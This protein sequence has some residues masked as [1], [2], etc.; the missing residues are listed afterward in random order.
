MKRII[1]LTESDLTRI[2]RRVLSEGRTEQDIYT[3]FKDRTMLE[4]EAFVYGKD[5][6]VRGSNKGGT[7]FFTYNCTTGA[8]KKEDDISKIYTQADMN[9]MKEYCNFAR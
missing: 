8:L 1:R 7:L 5:K 2:V 9:D 4:L 3:Q 6:I